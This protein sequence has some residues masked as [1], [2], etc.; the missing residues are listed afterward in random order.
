MNRFITPTFPVIP[1]LQFITVKLYSTLLTWRHVFFQLRI[2]TF[3][4]SPQD[5]LV[6]GSVLLLA[7][8]PGIILNLLCLYFL[9][10]KKRASWN[11]TF[12]YYGMVISRCTCD[13]IILAIYVSYCVPV[14]FFQKHIYG[15]LGERFVGF[16]RQFAY[17]SGLFHVVLIAVN[18]YFGVCQ[19]NRYKTMFSASNTVIFISTGWIFGALVSA[20]HWLPQCQFKF[21]YRYYTWG[22][23]LT[24]K[25]NVW[26]V[27]AEVIIN[28]LALV[29]LIII[30]TKVFFQLKMANRKFSHK[31]RQSQ[32]RRLAS[33]T[34]LSIEAITMTAGL[35]TV[36]VT[37]V[38]IPLFTMN[39]WFMLVNSCLSVIYSSLCACHTY[40]YKR[41]LHKQPSVNYK[42]FYT[43]ELQCN[44]SSSLK[45][46]KVS[47][48]VSA[49]MKID[50]T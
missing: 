22:Y 18:R 50:V 41:K 27:A 42:K 1:L 3:T 15:E 28:V 47:I 4:V 40:G 43:N 45:N 13:L 48:Q 44:S 36:W 19:L 2:F 16:L 11:L 5:K 8:F 10:K 6:G 39:R 32:R 23:P 21:L 38:M 14:V 46:T 12:P 33:E 31:T 24:H 29:T 9:L 30:Y 49:V 7:S 26:I 17:F 25:C 20:V 37:S 34:Q 35:C